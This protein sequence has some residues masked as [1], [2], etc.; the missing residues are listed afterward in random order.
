MPAALHQP[1]QSAG[2]AD[3]AAAAPL[4]SGA[5]HCVAVQQLLLALPL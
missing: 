5:A 3:A 1:G 4:G 2:P